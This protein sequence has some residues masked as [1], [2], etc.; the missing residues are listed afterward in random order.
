MPTVEAA[1]ATL[2][3]EVAGDGPT[4]VFAHGAGGNRMSWWQQAPE[5]VRD[6]RVIRLDLRSF[7]RS[8][9][10][11]GAVDPTRFA[12]DLRVILDSE[13]VE[14]ASLVC[15]SLGGWMGLRTALE[16]PE[17]VTALVL[18]GTPGGI[19]HPKVLEAAASIGDRIQAEGVK[20]SAA[21]APGFENTQPELAFLYDQISGLNT[22]FDMQALG[23]IFDP[24]CAIT[25][26]R[27]GE[28]S[29]PTLMVL[30]GRDL[31][32]PIESLRAVSQLIPGVEVAEFPE[33]GHSVY[34]E[35]AGKFNPLVRGFIE[36]HEKA[37]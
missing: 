35:A 23:R 8:R 31:L 22:E 10:E 3:Y 14:R 37:D 28:L 4:V 13:G 29:V 15:Q 27:A 21:L 12:D 25:P 24:E 33:C 6:H 26:E 5:F 16:T 32:F 30:G 1:G 36:R 11:L 20:G 19:A 17:R 7:G 34:F 18:C 2:Y 9:C